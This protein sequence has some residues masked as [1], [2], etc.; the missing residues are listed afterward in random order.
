MTTTPALGVCVLSIDIF[1]DDGSAH[2]NQGKTADS[3]VKL[4]QQ[5]AAAGVP[6]T[7][8]FSA[9]PNSE[10]ESTIDLHGCCE[11]ALR[12]DPSWGTNAEERAAYFQTLCERL[13]MLR[14]AGFTVTTVVMPSASTPAR[15]HLLVKHGISAV[16]LA[17]SRNQT[18]SVRGWW[19]LGA[20]PAAK[21]L[22]PLRWGL[23]EAVV[24]VDLRG[25]GLRR[26]CRTVDRATRQSGMAIVAGDMDTLLN[27]ADGLR[28]LLDHLRRRR[29][30][31]SLM[32]DTLGG[33]VA[34]QRAP[35]PTP[36]R[37]IL[38]PAA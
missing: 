26:A 11:V 9:A 27:D 19:P 34:R 38:R 18:P 37:S 7:L 12:G 25:R 17:E 23:W 10:L 35:R 21:V 29:D 2:A 1:Q 32:L 30:E 13:S 6:A 8:G 22:N 15:D 3:A 36:A 28:R 33:L 16:Q 31:P 24:N 4:C 5:L 14:S 20:R